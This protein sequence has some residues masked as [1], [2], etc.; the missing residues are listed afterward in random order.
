MMNFSVSLEQRQELAIL[1]LFGE[2]DMMAAPTFCEIVTAQV[3]Q[4][5]VRFVVDLKN[6]KYI[7]SRGIHALIT[8]LG[9]V[10][11]QRGDIRLVIGN[12]RIARVLALA[13]VDQVFT[14]YDD[15]RLALASARNSRHQ[16]AVPRSWTRGVLS[17]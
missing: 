9:A 17:I 1:E 2:F 11:Q 8:M 4:G 10:Q 15:R 13:G 6:L 12:D 7:D 5:I 16:V 14:S 3:E